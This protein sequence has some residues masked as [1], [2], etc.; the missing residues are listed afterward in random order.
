MN[1]YHTSVLLNE[2]IEALAITSGKKYIDATIGGGGH[3]EAIREK[4]GKVLGLDQD[5]D[6][7]VHVTE[8]FKTDTEVVIIKGNFSQID[9]I[10]KEH[11]FESVSGVLFDLGVSGYQ[12]DT[13]ERGFSFQ[14]EAV[15]DMRMDQT[16][17]VKA[18]DLVNALSVSELQKLFE[19]LGEEPF[20]QRIAKAIVENRPIETTK[21]LADVVY[22][23][24]TRRQP[25]IHPATKVFQALRIAVNDELHV[26]EE[27]LPKAL[28]LLQSGGRLVV[29]S[30]HSLEDRQVKE[31]FREL[32]EATSPTTVLATNTSSL[33]VTETALAVLEG[34]AK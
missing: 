12:F 14:K 9:T 16:L 13:T 6:A 24:V 7:I 31:R 18:K 8:K 26:L 1:N 30:F 15:L 5:D 25:G 34:R 3:T 19:K 32:A 27:A 2:T 29:I 23:V 4:G 21:E 33:L 10:A 28:S 20:S 17:S 11:G 22:R